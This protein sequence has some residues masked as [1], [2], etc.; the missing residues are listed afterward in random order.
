M[1]KPRWY[2]GRR[3]VELLE[4]RL[5]RVVVRLFGV[6]EC[7]VLVPRIRG[8][9]VERLL[10][11]LVE[12]LAQRRYPKLPVLDGVAPVTVAAPRRRFLVVGVF[13]RL[14]LLGLWPLAFCLW[15]MHS[16]PG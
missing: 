8:A 16:I 9:F 2:C 5:L 6:E 14:L 10:P 3:T 7:H 11:G 15:N 12:C 13:V 1:F 4:D